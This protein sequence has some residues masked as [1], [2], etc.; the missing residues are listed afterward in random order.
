MEELEIFPSRLLKGHDPLLDDYKEDLVDYLYDFSSKNESSS[1]S[2]LGGW[3]SNSF[4]HHEESFQPLGNLIHKALEPYML[5]LMKDL[6]EFTNKLWIPGRPRLDFYN[7]WFNINGTNAVNTLH[8]HPHSIYS[9]VMW[10][11]AP[12]NCGNLVMVDPSAHNMFGIVPTEYEFQPV[13]GDIIIFPSHVP[14]YVKPNNS[15][16]DRISLSFNI[17]L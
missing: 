1:R 13:E 8:T 3:Q 7:V 12:E 2:S 6:E 5:K 11:K 14:H 15:D 10:I 17:T 9:G 16:E 4:M